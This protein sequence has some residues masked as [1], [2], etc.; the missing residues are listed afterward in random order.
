MSEENRQTVSKPVV[1]VPRKVE[2]WHRSIKAKITLN[3]MVEEVHLTLLGDER[4]QA[5]LDATYDEQAVEGSLTYDD[6]M[7]AEMI[8]VKA[9]DMEKAYLASQKLATI[10]KALRIVLKRYNEGRKQRRYRVHGEQVPADEGNS[11]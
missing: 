3:D 2:D 9:N 11:E 10:A 6:A 5:Y 8:R 4:Y 7:A 1:Q